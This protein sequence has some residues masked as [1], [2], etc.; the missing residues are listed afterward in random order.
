MLDRPELKHM[1]HYVYKNIFVGYNIFMV[2]PKTVDVIIHRSNCC[3]TLSSTST[4]NRSSHKIPRWR[5]LIKS[6]NR[7]RCR[8]L[9]KKEQREKKELATNRSRQ[10]CFTWWWENKDCL[11]YDLFQQLLILNRIQKSHSSMMNQDFWKV[12]LS[13]TCSSS[14]ALKISPNS[15]MIWSLWGSF[16]Y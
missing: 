2:L 10:A 7:P 3:Q 12:C 1:A 5:R 8:Y 15:S 14:A 9:S 11:R 6:N 13:S 4:K 16:S